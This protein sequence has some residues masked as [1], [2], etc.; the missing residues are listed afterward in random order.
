MC[1]NV[2]GTKYVIR[3]DIPYVLLHLLSEAIEVLYGSMVNCHQCK[4]S[5]A[6]P[7]QDHL[8]RKY[9]YQEN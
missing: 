9:L 1:L 4:H 3:K 2:I 7:V 8:V 6:K 5:N